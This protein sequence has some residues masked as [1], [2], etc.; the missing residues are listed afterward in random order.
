VRTLRWKCQECGAKPDD[1]AKMMAMLEVAPF[2]N[3]KEGE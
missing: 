2:F 1:G 3:R